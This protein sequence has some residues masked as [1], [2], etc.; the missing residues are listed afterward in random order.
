ML[1]KICVALSFVLL[2]SRFPKF[3]LRRLEPGG[4]HAGD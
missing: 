2:T 4:V 3:A 1:Q